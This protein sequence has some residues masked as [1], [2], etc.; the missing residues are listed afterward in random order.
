[1]TCWA[2]QA[3]LLE[4]AEALQEEAEQVLLGLT[5]FAAS[6]HSSVTEQRSSVTSCHN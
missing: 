3:L 6:Q 5:D 4:K 1:M 2:P